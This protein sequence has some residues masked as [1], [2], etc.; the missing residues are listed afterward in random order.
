MY[1]LLFRI[2]DKEQIFLLND[3]LLDLLVAHN[4]PHGSPDGDLCVVQLYGGRHQVPVIQLL[5]RPHR[6]HAPRPVQLITQQP[7]S[8]HTRLKIFGERDKNI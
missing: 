2:V 1:F 7:R 6:R 5:A 3:R 4:H 8:Q